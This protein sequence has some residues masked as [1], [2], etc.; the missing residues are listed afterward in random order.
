MNMPI[1]GPGSAENQSIFS[2]Q[3][4][5]AERNSAALKIASG[6]KLILGGDAAGTAV[7]AGL[8][9]LSKRFSAAFQNT[10]N[11][12]SFSQTSDG[13]LS[14]AQSQLNRL[15]EL[16]IRATDGTLTSGDRANLNAEF[17]KIRDNLSTQLDNASFNGT[18][19][20]DASQQVGGVVDAGG[21]NFNLSIANASQ[22]ISSISSADLSSAS[23]AFAALTSVQTASDNISASRARVNADIAAL[24]RQS[25]A[26]EIARLNTEAANSR[27][28]D[29]D[30]AEESTQLAGAHIRNQAATAILSQANV[31]RRNV[32]SLLQ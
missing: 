21:T 3:R 11:L 25:D 1:I 32:L 8:D 24:G 2:I 26:N 19:V 16:A 13:F 20:F 4:S 22:D 17:S 6:N 5:N 15:G 31:S 30:V 27:I 23:N 7:S 10:Q 18:K 12:S 28:R 29:A 9:A 14:S